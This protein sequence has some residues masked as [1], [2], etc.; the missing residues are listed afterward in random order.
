MTRMS[1]TGF[2]FV[3][4]WWVT[5]AFAQG[6]ATVTQNGNLRPTPSS[7]KPPIRLLTPPET[8]TLI[9]TAQVNGYYHVRT[10]QGEEGWIFR[11]SV[12]LGGSPPP[13][14]PT[15][16]GPGTEIVPQASCPAVGMHKQNGQ[17]VAYHAD[18]DAGLRNLAKRH[19]PDPNCAPKA[20]TLDD[21][22]SMQN[23]IDNT[24]ADARTTKTKFEPNRNLHNI[25]TFG[26]PM[27]EGDLVRLSAFLVKA[28][29]EGS[30]SVNCAGNDGTD[31]HISVGPKIA[32]PT[33]YDGIVAEMIPQ[34]PRPA[35][36]GSV[37]LNRLTGKQVLIVGGLFVANSQIVL[38]TPLKELAVP[39]T[40]PSPKPLQGSLRRSATA[41]RSQSIGRHSARFEMCPQLSPRDHA[42]LGV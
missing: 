37:T 29:D 3:I 9:N 12:K 4:L 21:A 10:A 42:A 30:E 7:A 34:V 15:T 40:G 18:S 20:F 25:A 5:I 6:T 36:W 26:G 33:E 24:F 35:G 17:L 2:L 32:H 19:V 41:T 16:C 39:V 23:F 8:L 28:R 22:R 13:P 38:R 1:R 11:N 14:P 27:S 31:I